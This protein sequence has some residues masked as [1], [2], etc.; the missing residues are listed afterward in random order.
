MGFGIIYNSSVHV[1]QPRHHTS[2]E[3]ASSLGI[4]SC[5]DS[6]LNHWPRQENLT[7][8]QQ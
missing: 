6:C 2:H 4:E 7:P 8:R 1:S 5:W 3:R